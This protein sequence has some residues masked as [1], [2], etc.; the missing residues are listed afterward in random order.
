MPIFGGL[1]RTDYQDLL[2]ALG[3]QLSQL[4]LS[5]IRVQE[6]AGD[7][8]HPGGGRGG[9]IVSGWDE[10]ARDLA[11]ALEAG[12][13]APAYVVQWLRGGGSRP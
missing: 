3:R 10:S 5:R 9:L 6:V 4:P 11:F 13:T 1:D 12:D 8:E 7:Y 2:R